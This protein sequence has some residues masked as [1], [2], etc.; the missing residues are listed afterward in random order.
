V[1]SLRARGTLAA[2]LALLAAAPLAG[3]AE[4]RRA[5]GAKWSPRPVPRLDDLAVADHRGA[6]ELRLLVFGDSGTGDETQR[7]AGRLMARVCRE[8]G[9]CDLALTTGD[10]VY[11]AGV[12]PARNGTPDRRFHERFE[13]AYEPLGRLDF[14]MIPG[15]HDWYTRGSVD[16]QVRYGR[17]SLRWRMPSHDYAVPL[18]PPWLHVYGLDTT[19][20]A[21]GRDDAQL[22]RAAEALC[23]G[24]GWRL[25]VGHHPVY[26]SGRHSDARGADPRMESRL[27]PL[28]ERC[29]VQLY[30]AGHDHHQEHVRAPAFD[31]IVEG[32]AARP[33]GL[34]R[35]KRWTA[36]VGSL[37]A[38]DRLGFAILEV[39]PE[40]LRVRLFGE[41]ADGGSRELH[42]QVLRLDRFADA[43]RRA[44]DCS[45]T[46]ARP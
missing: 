46:P 44:D 1:T 21:R 16:A 29:A 10:N 32:A 18:L 2:L 26:S 33:R 40:R 13:R 45:P 39:D 23:G 3:C 30:L 6:S 20:L 4:L 43:R 14:W 38:A 37:V 41:A 34:G 15:N 31:Q 35:P 28:I 11:P 25:L 12:R 42:C 5:T 19:A 36:G 8:L 17:S 27:V 9:G 24:A 22:E 7:R